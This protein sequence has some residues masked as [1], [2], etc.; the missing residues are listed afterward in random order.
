MQ[1]RLRREK[2]PTTAD[3]AS[4]KDAQM[5]ISMLKLIAL[6]KH[7]RITEATNTANQRHLPH[8]EGTALHFPGQSFSD[9]LF[10]F[11]SVK[12][13]RSHLSMKL[14]FSIL[15]IYFTVII[16]GQ[17]CKYFQCDMPTGKQP[18]LHFT[19]L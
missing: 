1:H 9:L 11:L 3:K 8:T 15:K 10:W 4:S 5:T 13:M 6:S 16:H 18:F 7:S 19:R 17:L 14:D 2:T 12:T